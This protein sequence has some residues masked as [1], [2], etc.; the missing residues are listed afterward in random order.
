MGKLR[1]N[2][3]VLLV[4]G[5]GC[6]FFCGVAVAGEGN[7]DYDGDYD[8]DGEDF[9]GWAECMGG[10]E[11]GYLDPWSTCSAFDFDGDGDVDL[12]DLGGFQLAFQQP[13]APTNGSKHRVVGRAQLGLTYTY[14]EKKSTFLISIILTENQH[15]II[16]QAQLQKD[17]S[18]GRSSVCNRHSTMITGACGEHLWRC[19]R[20]SGSWDGVMWSRSKHG[21][22]CTG[23][24]RNSRFVRPKRCRPTC[25]FIRSSA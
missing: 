11:A 2:Q 6:Y 10:A 13:P 17:Y 12:H 25:S 15:Q 7:G 5:A 3:L 21:T 24:T 20:S 19:G 14:W 9:A 4:L 16:C 23:P 18:T 8:V 1:G 22:R